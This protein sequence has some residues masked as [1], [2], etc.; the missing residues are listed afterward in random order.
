[1]HESSCF[2]SI[3]TPAYNESKN[4]PLLYE[5]IRHAL[6]QHKWEWI[7]VDDHSSDSTFEKIRELNANDPK[8]RGIRLS[9]NFGSHAAIRCGIENATGKFVVILTGDL[10]D[11]PELIPNLIE[12]WEK[13]YQVVL[14]IR[15]KRP[16]ESWFNRVSAHLFYWVGKRFLGFKGFEST[17]SDYFL[18]DRVVVES[19]RKFQESN[20]NL[21]ALISWIGFRQTTIKYEK[22]VRV[23]GESGWTFEKRL[24]LFIDS[25]ASFSYLPIRLLTYFGL[26]VSFI[27]FT[28]ATLIMFNAFSGVRPQGWASLMV[29]VL[30]LSGV[31]MIMLG[32]LGEYLWRTLDESRKRPSYLI[33][34]VVTTT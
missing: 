11:P 9:R 33:E 19:I 10:Q 28:Y 5:R 1:M 3:V 32:L 15:T 17:G 6:G 24:K 30:F 29:V 7:I 22:T 27:G 21:I 13:G 16:K 20:V 2:A 4:L 25:I 34:S 14:A 23:H 12:Q 8:V 26:A 31:T 18:L